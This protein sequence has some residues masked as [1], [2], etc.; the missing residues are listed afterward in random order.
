[1]GGFVFDFHHK[2]GDVGPSFVPI[3]FNRL[4]LTSQGVI[5]L[6]RCGYLPVINPDDIRDKS[7]S[8]GLAK[9]L[10][11]LQASWMLIRTISSKIVQLPVSLLKVNTVAH[12]FCVFVIYDYG[13]GSR[14]RFVSQRYCK[15]SGRI[16]S[17]HLCS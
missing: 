11:I 2:G 12:V 1:M 9:A 15:G 7:K 8:D 14:E 16:N 5:L 6:A 3:K 10:V 17:Q 13:G 4:A